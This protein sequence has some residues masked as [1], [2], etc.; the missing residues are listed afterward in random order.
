MLAV[1]VMS[2][3]SCSDEFLEVA[4]AGS[5]S[6]AELTTLSGLEGTLIGTYAQ[7]LGRSGFYTGANNWF[8][9]S[10]MGGDANKGTTR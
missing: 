1:V 10:V 4:P 3:V 7:L 9:G 2:T 6:Q 8:W 5:L